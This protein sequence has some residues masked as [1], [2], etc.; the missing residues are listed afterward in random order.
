M[1]FAV[2][3]DLS[4]GIS[5][6]QTIS[7]SALISEADGFVTAMQ[8]PSSC[9]LALDRTEL[10]LRLKSTRNLGLSQRRFDRPASLRPLAVDNDGMIGLAGLRRV[11]AVASVRDPQPGRRWLDDFQRSIRGLYTGSD[12]SGIHKI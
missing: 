9:L 8:K 1:K 10:I 12:A 4:V 5:N 7:A 3:A 2:N 6:S 11:A